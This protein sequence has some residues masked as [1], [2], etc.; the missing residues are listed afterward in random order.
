MAEIEA[1][2]LHLHTLDSLSDDLLAG[3]KVLFADSAETGEI[4]VLSENERRVF[5]WYS[6]NRGKWAKNCLKEDVEAIAATLGN[7]LPKTRDR[8]LRDGPKRVRHFHL[9]KIRAFRFGGLHLFGSAIA[10]KPPVFEFA[11]SSPMTLVQGK[12]GSGKTSLLNAITW[13]L[14]GHVFRPSSEPEPGAG[15]IEVSNSESEGQTWEL[16]GVTPLPPRDALAG[17]PSR[18]VPLDTWVELILGTEDGAEYA[19]RRELT[20]TARGNVQEQITGL[21]ELGLDP[22]SLE[23]GTKMP[24]LLPY[25]RL[26]TR[27]SELGKA[28]AQLTGLAP[29]RDLSK[30][31]SKAYEK[32]TAELPKERRADIAVVESTYLA[33]Q[34][35]LDDLVKVHPLI[36]EK[37]ILV[38][39]P[40]DENAASQLDALQGQ[41]DGLCAQLLEDVEGVLTTDFDPSVATDRAALANDLP[42]CRAACRPSNL[43]TLASVARI[44]GLKGLEENQLGD[45]EKVIAELEL[46]ASELLELAK[47]PRA[48]SRTRLY[49]SVGSWMRN[50]K[51]TDSRHCPVCIGELGKAKDPITNVE[52]E[53][54][55][56]E[57][58]NGG[59]SHLSLT[60]DQ[61]VNSARQRLKDALPTALA[62]ELTSAKLVNPIS[63]ISDE[64]VDDLFRL[65]CFSGP[66]KSLKAKLKDQARALAGK[67]PSF[68]VDGAAIPHI[69]RLSSALAQMIEKVRAAIA[70]AR[71]RRKNERECRI[72]YFGLVGRDKRQATEQQQEEI[73][74]PTEGTLLDI[75]TALDR[76]VQ[77][78]GPAADA[79]SLVR[80]L[81]KSLNSRAAL[82]SRI[83]TY[84]EASKAVK[85][86]GGLGTLVDRQIEGLQTHLHEKTEQLRNAIYQSAYSNSASPKLNRTRVSNDGS[87]SLEVERNGTCAPAQIVGNASDLRAT[88][89]AFLFSFWLHVSKTRGGLSIFLLDDP[90]ELFDPDNRRRVANGIPQLVKEGARP[91]VACNDDRFSEKLGSADGC[92]RREIKPAG[93]V[94]PVARVLPHEVS[95]DRKRHAFESPVNEE[96]HSI[97]QDYVGSLREWLEGQFADFFLPSAKIFSSEPTL[98]TLIDTFRSRVMSGSE[99]FAGPAALALARCSDLLASSS[100]YELLNRAHH[101]DRAT[102]TAGEVRAV[103]G[104]LRHIQNLV[105]RAHEELELWLSRD[106]NARGSGPALRQTLSGEFKSRPFIVPIVR[107]LAAFT[108]RTI[109]HDPQL[110]EVP[111][112]D[113][114]FRGTGLFQLGSNNFGFS[115]PK[116]SIAI[117]ELEP[118]EILDSRLVI[119]LV[120]GKVYARRHIQDQK[121]PKMIALISE[122]ENPLERAPSIVI[123][124][125]QAQLH[126]VVGILFE[127]RAPAVRIKGDAAQIQHSSL[128]DSVEVAFKVRQDSA[129]PLAIEGQLVI[130]GRR[131][132]PREISNAVGKVVAVAT[133]DGQ[134]A[135]KRLGDEVPGL[136]GVHYFDSIGGK[137]NSLIARIAQSPRVE[138]ERLAIPKIESLRIILGVLY[139]T[140]S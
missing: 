50:E 137:G 82:E 52:I 109:E 27:P 90:Q 83:E 54:L 93:K 47:E 108:T 117:V 4:F 95:I 19:V 62:A 84:I 35:K 107:D 77:S 88:L 106:L 22:I 41:L 13:C 104:Q 63:Q 131:V 1:L 119:A 69:A 20:R 89:L 76:I 70:A 127:D 71:W 140:S 51:F 59:R 122:A 29:L 21:S 26:G 32:L 103:D 100:T 28:I 30:H 123:P 87:L 136:A 98:G 45:A 8:Q 34:K 126:K 38:P 115:A 112:T 97:A 11:C 118:K 81:S 124:A 68:E 46:Q 92:D 80:A 139:V 74:S 129:L 133:T 53:K 138:E 40:S 116:H 6:Q 128:L 12:N 2:P 110:E 99:A 66:L 55:L 44:S 73:E 105:S 17:F 114:W 37:P 125:Q 78:A 111:L 85:T 121:N 23:L 9:L 5:S 48:A 14:T 132:E 16:A 56:E 75:L 65:E 96:D 102:I 94:C 3:R 91:I 31:A 72:F 64:M 43:L 86:L 25:I 33:D 101:R 134:H 79:A 42:L 113:G 57:H 10:D 15:P 135:L 120:D 49:A 67:L 58:R 7:A 24:G 39:K 61:W 130:G 18:G 36:A 60:T